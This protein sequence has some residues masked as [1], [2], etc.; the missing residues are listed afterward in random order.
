MRV[1]PAAMGEIVALPARRREWFV[2]ARGRSLRMTWHEP[3]EVM[4]VS[5]WQVDRCVGTFHLEAGDA[6]RLTALG[7]DVVRAWAAS[8]GQ[9]PDSK[10]DRSV[11][12]R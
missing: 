2:D 3:E 8:H 5:I 12:A 9:P 4:V 1:D 6:A 7:A 10:L 11:S